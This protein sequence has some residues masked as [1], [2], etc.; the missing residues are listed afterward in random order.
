MS[1]TFKIV[2]NFRP[3]RD[4]LDLWSMDATDQGLRRL[5]E[6][7]DLPVSGL[8]L[9]ALHHYDSRITGEGLKYLVSLP[10]LRS[11]HF[12]GFTTFTDAEFEKLSTLTRL[13]DLGIG[14]MGITDLQLRDL[15]PL[16]ALETLSLPYTLIT[17]EGFKYL[18]SLAAL[19]D[20]DLTETKVTDAGL[21]QITRLSGL[22][23]LNLFYTKVTD[24]GL[25]LIASLS[26]LVTLNLSLTDV[27]DAGI[28][29]LA[30]L[31]NLT[32]LELVG[33][34]VTKEG[35]SRL[36]ARAPRLTTVILD[37]EPQRSPEEDLS[38]DLEDAIPF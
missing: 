22:K 4:E 19:T 1:D 12:S 23:S 16:A 31:S 33:T 15:S 2:P 9:L 17:G 13:E 37:G 32:T 8:T 20:I 30:R 24:A 28:G 14:C 10:H 25:S 34:R 6:L 18:A 5:S 7:K 35:G 38:E 27:S 11:L 36:V 26:E 21:K 3:D 29:H